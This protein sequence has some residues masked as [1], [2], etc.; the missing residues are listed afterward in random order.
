MAEARALITAGSDLPVLGS[1]L[2]FWKAIRAWRVLSSSLPSGVTSKRR[3]ASRC[4]SAW[5]VAS[6]A[7][8]TAASAGWL[9]AGAAGGPVVGGGAVVGGSVVVDPPE[10]AASSET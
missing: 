9:P 6:D 8:L 2:S 7:G 3:S 4:S 5:G 10:A 1:P